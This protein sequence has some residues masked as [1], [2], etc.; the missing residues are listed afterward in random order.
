MESSFRH[1]AQ[2]S[3]R[4][5]IPCG[6]AAL[7][8]CGGIAFSGQSTTAPATG[9]ARQVMVLQVEGVI[10]P[11]VAEYLTSYLDAAAA[12]E[13]ECI[14]IELDTPG[15]LLESTDRIVKSILKCD[16]PV[17]TFVSPEGAQAKSAGTFIV[18]ASH[19]AA[20]APATDIGAA[21]P[22][23]AQGQEVTEK[24]INA[25]ASKLVAIAQRR[26]R[27][28]EWAR[29]AVL[30]AASAPSS[31][32]LEKNVIDLIASGLPDLLNKLN[33]RTVNV[34]G[35]DR[36]LRTSGG[37]LNLVKMNWV[38]H[39]FQTIGHPNVAYILLM[40][41]IWGLYFELANPGIL[42]PGIVGA[43]CLI[44]GMLALSVL[45]VSLSGV[46]LI[47]L[48]VVFFVAELFTPTFGILSAGG[49]IAF[50]LGSFLL[51]PASP[52]G[53]VPWSLIIT[54]SV[55]TATF[56]AFVLYLVVKAHQKR[57][58]VGVEKMVGATGKAQSVLDPNGVVLVQGEQ[59][60]ARS[61]SGRIEDGDTVQV[62]TVDGLR[63]TVRKVDR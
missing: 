5:A 52:Y 30:K 25:T 37:R 29:Q 14:V 47:L 45:P 41:G 18:M 35:Q 56:M 55:T 6:L 20:M 22:V 11:M 54:C 23:G 60:S 61:A 7:L 42:F 50:V 48:A 9:S 39:L 31:E 62:E 51:F 27:N 49:I 10:G 2:R 57:V 15:G 26:G 53:R 17:I 4:R 8:I 34:L 1:R 46:L 24:I 33:G 36:V 16:V 44:L 32:A 19:V 59:W 21:T 3:L 43:L 28:A 12:G 38:Q 58:F 63:L 40:L 13:T